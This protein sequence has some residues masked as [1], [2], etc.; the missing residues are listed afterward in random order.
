[1]QPGWRNLLVFFRLKFLAVSLRSWECDVG[2]GFELNGCRKAK[3]RGSPV[4][5]EPEARR[6]DGLVDAQVVEDAEAGLPR[7]ALAGVVG[8]LLEDGGVFPAP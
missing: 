3:K 1:M 2:R 7:T 6:E 5:Q 4:V 8:T